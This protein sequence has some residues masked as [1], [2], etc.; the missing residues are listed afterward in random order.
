MPLEEYPPA[1]KWYYDYLT[2]L[3]EFETLTQNY[4]NIADFKKRAKKLM[5]KCKN[6]ADFKAQM[7]NVP[8]NTD[9]NTADMEKQPE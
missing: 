5:P 8:E 6:M 2:F 7:M 4:N 3:P 1:F 9:V